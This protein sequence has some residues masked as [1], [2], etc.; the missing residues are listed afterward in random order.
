MLQTKS[1]SDI[2]VKSL[3][4]YLTLVMIG[5]HLVA[6]PD[7]VFSWDQQVSQVVFKEAS[8]RL[9]FF[10]RCSVCKCCVLCFPVPKPLVELHV[11]LL[12]K[13]GRSVTTDRWEKYLAKVTLLLTTLRYNQKVCGCRQSTLTFE[14]DWR[15]FL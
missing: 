9:F 6:L 8:A 1:Q 13:L 12:R 3:R 15:C 4:I 5:C 14:S 2:C 11:K 7:C 10:L